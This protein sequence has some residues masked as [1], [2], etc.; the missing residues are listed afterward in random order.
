[1]P[2]SRTAIRRLRHFYRDLHPVRLLRPSDGLGQPRQIIT[3]RHARPDLERLSRYTATQ[4]QQYTADYDRAPIEAFADNTFVLAA[5][6]LP[7]VY[8]ST[9]PRA[10]LT[11]EALFGREM[12]IERSDLFIELEREVPIFPDRLK[13]PLR[14]WQVLN[15]AQYFG[16]R[17][18]ERIES[19]ARA[20]VRIRKAATVLEAV[21]RHEGAALVVAHGLFNFFLGIALQRRGWKRVRKSGRS[22]LGVAIYVEA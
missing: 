20:R 11:A 21:A 12:A 1:M 4:A 2:L 15:R 5:G 10:Y 13:L 9:L 14:Y 16:G 18:Y 6:E 8:A 22:H 17:R 19:F 7:R 3:I